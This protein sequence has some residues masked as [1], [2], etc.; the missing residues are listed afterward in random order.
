[1]VKRIVGLGMLTAWSLFGIPGSAF[2]QSTTFYACVD[3]AKGGIRM[4][5][6]ATVCGKSESKIQWNDPGPAGPQGPTGPSGATGPTGPTGPQGP[7]GPAGTSG[8][9]NSFN[10]PADTVLPETGT[11]VL[12]SSHDVSAGANDLHL[13]SYGGVFGN[14]ASSG[15]VCTGQMLLFI[16]NAFV[17][18]GITNLP[19]PEANFVAAELG[20]GSVAGHWVINDGQAHIIKLYG[21]QLDCP[22]NQIQMLRP[23]LSVTTLK[24]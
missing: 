20:W 23:Y 17:Q 12:V 10:H 14:P 7:A 15:V 22:A 18:D 16:D 9:S 8:Q 1:M 5:D 3:G 2:A 19:K 6:A 4:V 21:R 11:V 13:I 24:K